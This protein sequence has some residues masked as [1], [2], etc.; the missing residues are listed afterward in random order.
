VPSLPSGSHKVI[1]TILVELTMTGK[2][3]EV[4]LTVAVM[5]FAVGFS[6]VTAP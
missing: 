4:F 3:I 1:I 2:V 5:T 6:A